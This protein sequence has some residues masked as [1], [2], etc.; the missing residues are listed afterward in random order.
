MAK[1]CVEARA[2]ASNS[3]GAGISKRNPAGGHLLLQARLGAGRCLRVVAQ[4]Q[5]AKA[6]CPDCADDREAL[7]EYQGHTARSARPPL[8]AGGDLRAR[9]GEFAPSWPEPAPR[10][11]A[12][13]G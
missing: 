11:C 3:F 12:S 7:S 2:S 8:H 4:E 6:A 5:T 1:G 13:G 10:N 9:R